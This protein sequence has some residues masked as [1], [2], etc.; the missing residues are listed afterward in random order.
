V[1]A[2]R[3]RNPRGAPPR[4]SKVTAPGAVRM[5]YEIRMTAVDW[6]LLEPHRPLGPVQQAWYAARPDGGA[7]KLASLVRAGANPIAVV[8]PMGSG[9]ST[10]VLMA[11]TLLAD[12]VCTM[13]A[14]DHMDPATPL[15]A[16]SSV[17][18]L[19]CGWL[20][21]DAAPGSLSPELN[22]KLFNAGISTRAGDMRQTALRVPA[23]DLLRETLREVRRVHGQ[24]QAVI[25]CDGLEKYPADN[26]REIL[27]ALVPFRSDATLVVVVPTSLAY[28]PASY[29][30]VSRFKL[31]HIRAAQVRDE[32]GISGREGR[33]FLKTIV[34]RRLGFPTPLPAWMDDLLNRAAEASGGVPRAFLQ[35]VL[36]AGMYA[37]LAQREWPS[38]EDLGD[39]MRDH[40]ESLRRLLVKGDL[41]ALRAA[42]G[43]DGLEVDPERRLRLLTHGLLLE[44]KLGERTVVHPAPL[45]AG[46]PAVLG[47]A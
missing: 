37:R 29:D 43:T 44:Y 36:D 25:F 28:G 46:I 12:R 13:C 21:H 19:L 8:G 20:T 27:E 1:V 16:A 6:T 9:K 4:S 11:L 30:I 22:Q 34:T 33:E 23:P 41:D 14:V 24:K 26:A 31:F 38:K 7:V 2:C 35:L 47:A 10:E 17:L 18:D 39:A 45:I 3:A 40:A 15:P 42:D 5:W 32:G